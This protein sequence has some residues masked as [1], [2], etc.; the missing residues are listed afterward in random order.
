MAFFITSSCIFSLPSKWQTKLKDQPVV[1]EEGLVVGV[2]VI[3]EGVAVE[4]EG[5]GG[6]AGGSLKRKR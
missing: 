2:V 3:G 1:L 5:G 4:G 6:G